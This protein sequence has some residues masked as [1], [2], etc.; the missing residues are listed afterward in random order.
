MVGYL[1]SDGRTEDFLV[2][3]IEVL[4]EAVALGVDLRCGDDT[5]TQVE[6][7]LDDEL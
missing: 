2:E 4:A 5:R 1:P 6:D 3:V 7:I